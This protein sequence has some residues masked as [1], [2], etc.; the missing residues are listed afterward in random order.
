MNET[1]PAAPPPTASAYCLAVLSRR[2]P[3]PPNVYFSAEEIARV[4]LG[5]FVRALYDLDPAS[6]ESGRIPDSILREFAALRDSFRA[7][8][9]ESWLRK[10]FESRLPDWQSAL[11][12]SPDSAADLEPVFS[13]LFDPAERTPSSDHPSALPESSVTLQDA[14]FG[15]VSRTTPSGE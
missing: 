14:P 4:H 2:D 11:S 13:R 15:T 10:L 12:G 1:K 7:L 6:L 9:S 8:P 3:N 5:R